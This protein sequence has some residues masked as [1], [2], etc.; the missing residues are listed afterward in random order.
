MTE[1][2]LHFLENLFGVVMLTS[3]LWAFLIVRKTN[4][5]KNL[6]LG[7][8]IIISVV[9]SIVCYFLVVLLAYRAFG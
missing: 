8:G 3:P 5:N 4:W 1:S 7:L 6:K 9:L 2:Q